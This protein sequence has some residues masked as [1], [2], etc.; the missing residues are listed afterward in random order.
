MKINSYHRL[1]VILHSYDN[2]PPKVKGVLE[3]YYVIG[4]GKS[5]Y[6]PVL[7][8]L[9]ATYKLVL[10]A[11]AL[12]LAFFTRNIKVDVLNDYRYNTAI[13][14]GSTFLLLAVCSTQLPLF[15]YINWYDAV[16]SIEVFLFISLYLGLTF[17]PKVVNMAK[18]C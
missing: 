5:I 7:V 18:H 15:D 9:S 16:W 12:V 13:I 14:I 2:F 17:I 6:Y 4:C 10:H 11:V 8:A 1:H 3:I